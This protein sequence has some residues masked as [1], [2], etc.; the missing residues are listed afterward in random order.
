MSFVGIGFAVLA[1]MGNLSSG[2]VHFYL[3]G[4]RV[5][6]REGKGDM[7]SFCSRLQEGWM[8]GRKFFFFFFVFTHFKCVLIDIYTQKEQ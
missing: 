6:I 3:F 2:L 7:K 4:I 5:W 1:V 8:D